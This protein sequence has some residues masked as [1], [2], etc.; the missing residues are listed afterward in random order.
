MK[1]TLG[2]TIGAALLGAVAASVLFGITVVQ[3]YT[4]YHNFPKDWK[5]QKYAVA[6]LLLLE[7][8]HALFTILAIYHYLVD[9]FGD[10]G[11]LQYL[12]WSFKLQVALNVVIVLVV[13]GLYAWRVYRLGINFSLLWPWL[14][15]ILVAAGWGIGIVLTVRTYGTNTFASIHELEGIL[16]GSFI[17]ATIIDFAIATAICYYLQT[18]RT[19]F[20]G[21]A[22]IKTLLS[23]W[24]TVEPFQDK[25]Q[26]RQDYAIRPDLRF[27]DECLFALRFDHRTYPLMD[28]GPTNLPVK[29]QYAT[30]PT[31]LIF[32]GI[33]FLLPHLY[34][35]SYL[36]MLNARNSFNDD[37]T[38][39]DVSKSLK[40]RTRVTRQS[41]TTNLDGNI[42]Q[43]SI[44]LSPSQFRDGPQESKMYV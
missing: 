28:D 22:N 34:I 14:I 16:N 12:S 33:D 6:L 44:S 36:A 27:L 20:R 3:V 15:I 32:V 43:N 17:S 5:F 10:I 41:E 7:I 26:A 19:S 24:I 1:V 35:N 37:E 25:Q 39:L 42:H 29:S 13:Q 9:A 8:S 4:Y 31:N 38:S 11:A 40:F 30:M 23:I 21:Y 2:N 18:N